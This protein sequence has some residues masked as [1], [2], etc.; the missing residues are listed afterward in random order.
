MYHETFD[1]ACVADLPRSDSLRDDVR[2]FL[3][4]PRDPSLSYAAHAFAEVLSCAN[5][6]VGQTPLSWT[7]LPDLAALADAP[8]HAGG[9]RT[10]IVLIGGTEE[11]WRPTP[12]ELAPVRARLMSAPRL[13]TVGSGVFV[14]LMASRLSGISLS[15][16]PGFQPAVTE[17]APDVI[18][19]ARAVSHSGRFT[20]AI[21]ALA[22]PGMALDLVSR[23]LGG[24]T[25]QAVAEYLGLRVPY[26]HN[27]SVEHWRLMRK[28]KGNPLIG[29]ALT[30]MLD[31]LE[32]VLTVTEIAEIIG[33]SPRQLE[34]RF[35][36]TLDSSP[37]QIYR[38]LRLERARSLLMQTGLPIREIALASGFGSTSALNR[39]YRERFGEPPG[40]TRLKAFD[41]TCH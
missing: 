28:S 10:G 19:S 23:K 12:A 26:Q 7:H 34:R 3:L 27:R 41:G 16:H 25:G 39:W 37:L 35:R 38:T 24:F 8:S 18:F 36:T 17:L 30:I 1:T 11:A 2:H 9:R 4:V 40:R 31:H 21:S 22:A 32:E 5:R 15:V 20:T 14:A 13:C 33:I 6:L 29:Q